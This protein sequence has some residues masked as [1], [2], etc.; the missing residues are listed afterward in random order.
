MKKI[1]FSTNQEMEIIQLTDKIKKK[2]EDIDIGNGLLHVYAPHATGAIIINES[3]DPNVQKDILNKLKDIFPKNAGYEHDCIDNN[4][5]SHLM[6]TFL[7]CSETIPIE[8]GK[9]NL[10]TWQDISFVETD[11]PREKRNVYI[12]I[13]E[14]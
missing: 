2:M 6:S 12:Q 9:I 3:A 11:G 4:A 14:K 10:G 7:G 8:N 1:T 13:I 5:H